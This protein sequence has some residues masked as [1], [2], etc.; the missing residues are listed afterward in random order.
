MT[1]YVSLG[2]LLSFCRFCR[3]A[4]CT[5]HFSLF[6]FP[7]S[8]F[9]FSLRNERSKEL[10]RAFVVVRLSARLKQNE[11]SLSL[12][13]PKAGLVAFVIKLKTNTLF[14]IKSATFAA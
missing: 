5:L 3:M 10:K 4:I 12:S 13:I 6:V 7:S 11:G 8:F 2:D 14:R 1:E 9:T